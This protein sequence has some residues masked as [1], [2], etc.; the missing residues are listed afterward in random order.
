MRTNVTV[1]VAGDRIARIVD[2]FANPGANDTV[3]DL[4]DATLMPGL[5]DMHVHI[6]SQSSP[7]SYAEG[8]FMNPADVALRATTYMEKTLMAGFTTVRD[9][10]A[11]QKL[12]LALRDAVAKGWIRGRASSAPAA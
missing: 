6:T 11:G 1:V 3:V 2:G 4:R 12:N 8:F 5:M 7:A 9:L 10:G